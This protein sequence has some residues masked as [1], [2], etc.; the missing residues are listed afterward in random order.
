MTRIKQTQHNHLLDPRHDPRW[1]HLT[2]GNHQ[3]NAL[4]GGNAQASREA[5]AQNHAE[6]ASLKA[7][8]QRGRQLFHQGR[9]CGF[10]LGVDAAQNHAAHGV[11]P[12]NEALRRH[13]R[14]C[15]HHM[16]LRFQLRTQGVHIG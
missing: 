4:T 15:C 13:K 10:R 3:S 16:R 9:D 11:T 8:P 5:A 2:A 14:G 7:F 6:L 1:R 12:R